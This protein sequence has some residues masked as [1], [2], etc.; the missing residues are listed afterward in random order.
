MV[1]LLELGVELDL[2]FIIKLRFY[3][4][5]HLPSFLVDNKALALMMM[6]RRSKKKNISMQFQSLP[7]AFV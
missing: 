2:G 5:I 6:R 3:C 1:S 4:C 7:E